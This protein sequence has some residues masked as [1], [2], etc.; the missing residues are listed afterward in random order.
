MLFRSQAEDFDLGG[1]AFAWKVNPTDYV[2]FNDY[3]P[4]LLPPMLGLFLF[5]VWSGVAMIPYTVIKESNPDE[6]KGSATGIQNFLVFGISALVGPLFGHLLGKTLDTTGDHLA[7]FRAALGF[8]MATIAIALVVSLF[9]RETGQSASRR[10]AGASSAGI[11]A[12]P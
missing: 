1:R 2:A 3:R 7:H 10:V 11:P 5:G 9:L 12:R 6:V 4:G 8:W